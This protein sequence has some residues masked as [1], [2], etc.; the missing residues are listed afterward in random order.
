MEVTV[1]VQV[2]I[3]PETDFKKIPPTVVNTLN[4]CLPNLGNQLNELQ[5]LAAQFKK[6]NTH[7]TESKYQDFVSGLV[8]DLMAKGIGREVTNNGFFTSVKCAEAEASTKSES[9]VHKRRQEGLQSPR[10][11]TKKAKVL[12]GSS[13]VSKVSQKRKKSQD[14]NDKPEDSALALLKK[15]YPIWIPDISKAAARLFT[16]SMEKYQVLKPCKKYQVNSHGWDLFC[17]CVAHE[18]PEVVHTKFFTEPRIK[19]AL[20]SFTSW[21]NQVK[22]SVKEIKKP[23]I[24]S[25]IITKAFEKMKD[26]FPESEEDESSNESENEAEEQFSDD[27]EV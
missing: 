17:A 10:T 5:V 1:K 4:D 25:R 2:S 27:D 21:F 8:V 14:A 19:F 24:R 15:M 23:G 7:A 12:E 22:A 16:K 13:S 26:Y 20:P 3:K 6:E 11:L 18:D 9:G